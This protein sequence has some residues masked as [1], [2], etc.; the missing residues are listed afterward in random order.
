[1]IKFPSLYLSGQAM[2]LVKLYINVAFILA[3]PELGSSTTGIRTQ[4]A[5]VLKK[6]INMKSNRFIKICMPMPILCQFTFFP[7]ILYFLQ[8]TSKST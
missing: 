8:K 3:F 1:M 4:S 2:Y 6:T 5:D 7:D